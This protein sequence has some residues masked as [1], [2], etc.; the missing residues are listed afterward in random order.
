M[1]MSAAWFF[2]MYGNRAVHW[3]KQKDEAKKDNSENEG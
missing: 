1:P 2:R 3:K